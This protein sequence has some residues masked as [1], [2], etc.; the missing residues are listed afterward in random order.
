VELDSIDE[1]A[2]VD[3]SC[4]RGSLA[5]GF[6]V[7]LAGSSDVVTADGR[8]RDKIDA[9]DLDRTWSHAVATALLDVWPLPQPDRERDVSSQDVVAQFAAELHTPDG[10]G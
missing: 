1:R 8:E 10:S 2:L 7:G 5:E 6:A 9:V 4:V 3:R